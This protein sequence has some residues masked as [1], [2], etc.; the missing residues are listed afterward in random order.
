MTTTTLLLLALGL[1]VV[2]LSILI[3]VL[4]E[5]WRDKEMLNDILCRIQDLFL[6]FKCKTKSQ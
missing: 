5:V 6:N 2:V 1:L 3:G 4:A